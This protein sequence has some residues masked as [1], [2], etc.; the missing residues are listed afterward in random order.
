MPEDLQHPAHAVPGRS[1]AGG[2]GLAAARILS[3]H[4]GFAA[5]GRLCVPEKCT[6]GGARA[7]PV[8]SRQK[9]GCARV[10]RNPFIDGL[11]LNRGIHIG[12]PAIFSSAAVGAAAWYESSPWCAGRILSPTCGVSCRLAVCTDRLGAHPR[13]CPDPANVAVGK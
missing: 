12:G 3:N 11:R 5:R 4:G 7:S 13:L 10:W 2:E 1:G 9:G 6:S 8:K